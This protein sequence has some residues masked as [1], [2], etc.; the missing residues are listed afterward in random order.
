MFRAVIASLLVTSVA[1][2]ATPAEQAQAD[3]LVRKG[4]QLRSA[5]DDLNALPLFQ[6]AFRLNPGARTAALLG[7]AEAGLGRWA[8]ADQHLTDAL[9]S[10]GKDPWITRNGKTLEQ[11]L[12]NVKSRV[13]RVELTGDPEGAEVL[14]NGKVVGKLPLPEPVK[15][16]AGSVDLELR[17]P[18]YKRGFRT[19]ILTGGQ[20]QVV[21]M[22]LERETAGGSEPPSP[23][24]VDVSSGEPGKRPPNWRPWA[25][26][27]GIGGA[28]LGLGIGWYGLKKHDSD[29]ISFNKKGCKEMGNT[30]T[31]PNGTPAQ[32]QECAN[33]RA[34]YRNARTLT[35]VSFSAAGALAVTSA[36]L[37]LTRPPEAAPREQARAP[38]FACAPLLGQQGVTCAV[39]F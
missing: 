16:S 10:M 29:V 37:Y 32:N 33:L 12:S 1:I 21:V 11:T 15:V 3:A 26:W 20:Y 17:A 8:D 4:N 7:L 14:M 27:G 19:I 2:A 13:G 22:R 5:G 25:V 6:E 28:A 24:P 38:R 9:R 35:I 31:V 18:G 34:S 30:A 23:A 36:V 39:S